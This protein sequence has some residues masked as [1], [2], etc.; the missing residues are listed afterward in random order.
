MRSFVEV[1]PIIGILPDITNW[2]QQIDEKHTECPLV[3]E[4]GIFRKFRIEKSAS[5]ER[6][7]RGYNMLVISS[8]NINKLHIW[9]R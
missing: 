3:M 7:T 2:L 8:L 6:S 4:V 1:I 9:L 5:Q